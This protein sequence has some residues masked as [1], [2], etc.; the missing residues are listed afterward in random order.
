MNLK[1]MARRLGVSYKKKTENLE[2]KSPRAEA[3]LLVWI[4]SFWERFFWC[5]RTLAF[6]TWAAQIP[7]TPNKNACGINP[8]FRQSLM[9][10]ST[11]IAKQQGVYGTLSGKTN[12]MCLVPRCYRCQPLLRWLAVRKIVWIQFLLKQPQRLKA[13]RGVP[14]RWGQKYYVMNETPRE[15]ASSMRA[16]AV[17]NLQAGGTWKHFKTACARPGNRPNYSVFKKNHGFA[18]W[19]AR[20]LKI[21]LKMGSE[22]AI[23]FRP[24]IVVKAEPLENPPAFDYTSL[25]QAESRVVFRN[26]YEVHTDGNVMERTSSV[27]SLLSHSS[28]END[29]ISRS[30]DNEESAVNPSPREQ[31]KSEY[32][33]FPAYRAD[34]K[35]S[36]SGPGEDSEEEQHRE[37]QTQDDVSTEENAR[38]TPANDRN[39]FRVYSTDPV[40]HEQGLSSKG[41]AC[42]TQREIVIPGIP[43]NTH[44]GINIVFHK[45][46]KLNVDSAG[47]L[48][49][50]ETYSPSEGYLARVER[51]ASD[52]PPSLVYSTRSEPQIS[53]GSC[54]SQEAEEPRLSTYEAKSPSAGSPVLICQWIQLEK[55]VNHVC[56]MGFYRIEDLVTHITDVH[57]VSATPVGFVCCW[58]ECMRNGMPFKAKY[59]LINHIRVHTGEKPFTCNQPGCRKSFARAENLKIHVRTHTGERPFACEFKGCDKRFANSSDRRKHIHVHTLEKPYRCKY[60]GCDK[61]YTHPSSLRKHMKVHGLRSEEHFKVV[62]GLSLGSPPSIY[63]QRTDIWSKQGLA[64]QSRTFLGNTSVIHIFFLQCISR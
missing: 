34:W 14:W 19:R 63:R 36:A 26:Y 10:I 46:C 62:H 41:T 18:W 16:L 45:H 38:K 50:R 17:V 24:S 48:Y 22:E 44:N 31:V 20:R 32:F 8:H 7:V 54:R 2:N 58:K 43:S 56:G 4:L 9:I 5:H 42:Q 47:K 61:S 23:R 55:M 13:R 6:S 12:F 28:G 49:G 37:E 40:P 25:S 52:L 60:V 11:E 35:A 29:D 59:K 53:S 51:F 15:P 33:S 3:W 1:L 30:P 21:F 57:L 64:E 27:E 39:V